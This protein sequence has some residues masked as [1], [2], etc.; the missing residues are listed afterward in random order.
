MPRNESLELLDGHI[1]TTLNFMAPDRAANKSSE[2]TQ[3]I[4]P[5]TLVEDSK[6]DKT[7]REKTCDT[8]CD[9]PVV[10][11]VVILKV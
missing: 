2:K 11:I 9:L 8:V 5:F 10:K 3:I 4:S 7:E 1:M 6:D